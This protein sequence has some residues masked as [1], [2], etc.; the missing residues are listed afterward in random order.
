MNRSRIKRVRSLRPKMLEAGSSRTPRTSSYPASRIWARFKQWVQP[1]SPKNLAKKII[2]SK[3]CIAKER[4]RI[5]LANCPRTKPYKAPVSS[6]P[7]RTAETSSMALVQSFKREASYRVKTCSSSSQIIVTTAM[8]GGMS[9]RLFRRIE[10]LEWPPWPWKLSTF[11][12]TSTRL[13]IA[14]MEPR[15]LKK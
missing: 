11:K 9:R 1:G 14:K 7:K 13:L 3:P 12:S 5:I 4:H 2:A 15:R 8:T 10:S 6:A